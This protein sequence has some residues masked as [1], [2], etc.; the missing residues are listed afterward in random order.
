MERRRMKRKLFAVVLCALFMSNLACGQNMA[1][2]NQDSNTGSGGGN[3]G[4]GTG[5]MT[6]NGSSVV[7]SQNY[8]Q[9]CCWASTVHAYWTPDASKWTMITGSATVKI[10]AAP[11]GNTVAALTVATPGDLAVSY[12]LPQV[13]DLSQYDNLEVLATISTSRIG[14][15]VVLVDTSG[16]RRYYNFALR[17]PLGWLQ[18][19]YSIS[20]FI[21]EDTGFDL[22]H[23]QA[24]WFSQGGL[25]VGDV[26]MV[27][28]ITLANNLVDHG[29]FPGVWN[30]DLV[31]GGTLT[32]TSDAA[33]GPS[34]V[35]ANVA[36]CQHGQADIAINGIYNMITW[37]WSSKTSVSFY[38]KDPNATVSHYFLIY[39]TNYQHFREWVFPNTYPGQWMKVTANLT[40]GY[41]YQNGPVD[42]GNIVQFEV[43]VF[44]GQPYQLFSFQI[45]EVAL[46]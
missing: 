3:H 12:S 25:Q 7:V 30:K 37:D 9:Q 43:G 14:G 44:N 35:Y 27:G 19:V 20:N 41:Y 1:G 13:T 5:T 2:A 28:E 33:M 46:Q 31:C 6:S 36:A 11:N 29:D 34:S 38:F 18:L 40:S 8:L 17:S 32:A 39:D 22:T 10:Q 42:L 23:V 21:R 24:V 4:T 45:D 15:V 16:R 26:I